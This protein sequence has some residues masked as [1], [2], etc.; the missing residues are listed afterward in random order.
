MYSDVFAG[1]G[2]LKGGVYNSENYGENLYDFIPTGYGKSTDE[3]LAE[4]IESA[5]D[6]A[7]LEY[8]EKLENLAGKPVYILS[9]ESDRRYPKDL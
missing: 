4:A 9:G 3:A 6:Y 1:I 8:I 7:K 5:N 2:L